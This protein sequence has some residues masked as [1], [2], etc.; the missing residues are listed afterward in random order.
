MVFVVELL[1]FCLV[2]STEFSLEDLPSSL[3]S[4]SEISKLLVW[5]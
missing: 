5:R 1:V 4:R 3:E 2:L